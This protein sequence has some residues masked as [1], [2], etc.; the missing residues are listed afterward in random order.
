VREYNSLKLH[1]EG[2]DMTVCRAAKDVFVGRVLTG[3]CSRR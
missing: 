2:S 3:T 1:Y